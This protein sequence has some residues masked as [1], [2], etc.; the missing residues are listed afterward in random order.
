MLMKLIISPQ[1]FMFDPRGVK[2][3]HSAPPVSSSS[4]TF[5]LL[6]SFFVFDEGDHGHPARGAESWGGHGNAEEPALFPQRSAD[7]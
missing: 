4:S 7:V 1:R 2:G 5:L 6:Y 3:R